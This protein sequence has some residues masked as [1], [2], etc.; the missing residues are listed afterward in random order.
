MYSAKQ[1]KVGVS[2]PT[3][4]VRTRNPKSSDPPQPRNVR[5]MD[6]VQPRVERVQQ[7]ENVNKVQ[8]EN[9][10]KA[11]QPKIQRAK[12]VGSTF[13]DVVLGSNIMS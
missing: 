3:F 2:K 13:F 6:P 10:G 5:S 11:Q 1:S 12:Y 9:D 7:R 8:K 4:G